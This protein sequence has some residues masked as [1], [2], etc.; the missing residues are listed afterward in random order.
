MQAELSIDKKKLLIDRESEQVEAQR[1][2]KSKIIAQLE[3]TRKQETNT[4]K[5]DKE[6]NT[7]TIKQQV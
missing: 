5:E 3:L 1:N 7:N 4:S 2:A 6:F